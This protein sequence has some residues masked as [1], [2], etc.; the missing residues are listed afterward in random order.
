MT[1]CYS[2]DGD[3]FKVCDID[4]V[5]QAALEVD[6]CQVGGTRTIFEA[7]VIIEKAGNMLSGNLFEE[8]R[9]NAYDIYEDFARMTGSM[10]LI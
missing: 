10:T 5:V 4:D 7:D 2:S 3:N 8:M 1:K 6:L 9:D